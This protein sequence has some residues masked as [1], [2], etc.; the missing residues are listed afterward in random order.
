V[1]PLEEAEET[2]EV[3]EEREL[4]QRERIL[5]EQELHWQVCAPQSLR[6]CTGT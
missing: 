6:M 5:L 4:S 2:N 3:P 1:E